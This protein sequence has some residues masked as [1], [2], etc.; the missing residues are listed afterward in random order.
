MYFLFCPVFLK[1][2]ERF[3]YI[4]FNK[5]NSLEINLKKVFSFNFYPRPSGYICHS[6]GPPHYG[7][8]TYW[9]TNFCP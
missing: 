5:I 9:A 3:S 6:V 2:L 1:D 7:R 4:N 8:V